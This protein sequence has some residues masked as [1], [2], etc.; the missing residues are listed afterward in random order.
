MF[1]QNSYPIKK[2][3]LSIDLN[4]HW[5]KDVKDDYFNKTSK[6]YDY[7]NLKKW[8]KLDYSKIKKYRITFEETIRKFQKA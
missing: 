5:K 4:V 6:R 2:S 3:R 1:T 7:F 8:S